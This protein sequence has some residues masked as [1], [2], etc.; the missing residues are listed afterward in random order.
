MQHLQSTFGDT[1]PFLT[2]SFNSTGTTLTNATN[3]LCPASTPPSAVFDTIGHIFCEPVL[4]YFS[5]HL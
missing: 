4:S 3:D 5:S 2:P 1:R